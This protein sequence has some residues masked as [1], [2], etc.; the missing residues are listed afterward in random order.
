MPRA[1]NYCKNYKF[2]GMHY[3]FFTLLRLMMRALV[4]I[5]I[6]PPAPD[7]NEEQMI[8]KNLSISPTLTIREGFR[9]NVVVSKDLTFSKPYE[10]FDY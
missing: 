2:S 9:F 8:Q 1:S 4:T 5:K 7:T 10:S 6:S 3:L